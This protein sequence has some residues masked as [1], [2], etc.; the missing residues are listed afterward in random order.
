MAKIEY[1][2]PEEAAS[3]FEKNFPDLKGIL[4]DLGKNPFPSSFEIVISEK[5]SR[6]P[7][8]NLFLEEL[9]REEKVQDVQFPR[10]WVERVE[11]IGRI[12]KALGIFLASILILASFFI[13]SNV[14]RL[15]VIDR[16]EE[17]SILRMVG[18]TNHFI[19]FPFLL[20]GMILGILGSTAALLLLW[21]IIQLFPLYVGFP[22]GV[23]QELIH[24]RSLTLRQ[25]LSLVIGGGMVGFL[26]SLSA[27]SRFLKI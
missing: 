22:L 6:S 15:S 2:S 14:I 12:I 23:F 11:S 21:V 26:G 7:A 8:V 17:I 19:R 3:R 9:R 27:L 4:Q 18:A 24:L 20:E 13:V 16:Q 5:F 10:E 1:I 25:A